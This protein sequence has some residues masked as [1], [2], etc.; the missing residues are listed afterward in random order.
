MTKAERYPL[1]PTCKKLCF[2]KAIRMYRQCLNCAV[3]LSTVVPNPNG[4]GNIVTFGVR[5]H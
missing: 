5:R 2:Y 4:M 1:C 3:A